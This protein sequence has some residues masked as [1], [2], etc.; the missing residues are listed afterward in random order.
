MAAVDHIPPTFGWGPWVR[1]VPGDRNRDRGRDTLRPVW[2]QNSVAMRGVLF[3]FAIAFGSWLPLLGVHDRTCRE[4][5]QTVAP[6]KPKVDFARQVQPILAARCQPCHFPGG[7]MHAKLP[8]DQ[9]ATIRKLGTRLFSRIRDEKEQALIRAFL[10][11]R[12]SGAQSA[13]R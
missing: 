2:I 8:F 3:I 12:R 13:E 5:L 4:S 9:P 7:S 1:T 10:G 11:E 6:S